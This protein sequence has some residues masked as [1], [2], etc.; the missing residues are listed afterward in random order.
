MLIQIADLLK[1]PTSK[2]CHCIKN[3]IIMAKHLLN[4]EKISF[5]LLALESLFS[6]LLKLF[7]RLPVW[8]PT[9]HHN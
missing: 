4:L 1:K 9:S 3:C 6:C 8:A 7:N 5:S 2:S